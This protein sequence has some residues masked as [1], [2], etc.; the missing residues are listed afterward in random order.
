MGKWL[1]YLLVAGA[2]FVIYEQWEKSEKNKK[3]I[4]IKQ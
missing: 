1:K 3:Q 4:K 2:L